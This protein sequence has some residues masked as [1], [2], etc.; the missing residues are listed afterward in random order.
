MHLD[1]LREAIYEISSE[2]PPSSLTSSPLDLYGHVA[3]RVA[4]LQSMSAEELAVSIYTLLQS[5]NLHEHKEQIAFCVAHLANKL[6]IMPA[7][8]KRRWE[9]LLALLETSPKTSSLAQFTVPQDEGEDECDDEFVIDTWTR[10]TACCLQ[11]QSLPV[12]EQV[13]CLVDNKEAEPFEHVCTLL[14]VAY[15]AACNRPDQWDM[16]ALAADNEMRE[17]VLQVLTKTAKT[18]NVQPIMQALNTYI[19]DDRD[20]STWPLLQCCRS[21]F[22]PL[23]NVIEVPDANIAIGI[24]ANR[25]MALDDKIK[26]VQLVLNRVPSC[27][28]FFLHRLFLLLVTESQDVIRGIWNI[29]AQKEWTYSEVK[30]EGQAARVFTEFVNG[31]LQQLLGKIFP[32]TKEPYQRA[33]CFTFHAILKSLQNYTQKDHPQSPHAF[34][35]EIRE[36]VLG[37]LARLVSCI[38]DFSLREEKNN[39]LFRYIGDADL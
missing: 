18:Q 37:E 21:D 26:A 27:S 34:C 33:I 36:Q 23:L 24:L 31:S 2:S 25:Y 15:F 38:E 17:F 39:L 9:E 4:A 7:C 11:E 1:S 28:L 6:I 10:F 14:L 32:D 20:D 30:V 19:E 3:K 13:A 12:V 5:P 8:N 29:V 16:E 22:I 35:K